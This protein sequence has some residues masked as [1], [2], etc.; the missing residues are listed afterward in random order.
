MAV[1]T[2]AEKATITALITRLEQG[3]EIPSPDSDF[4]AILTP[5]Q[6]KFGFT[7]A[8]KQ[9]VA[10]ALQNRPFSTLLKALLAVA[11]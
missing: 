9:G 2:T 11:A 1:L 5:L 7:G 6:A 4:V 8:G 10:I 3:V